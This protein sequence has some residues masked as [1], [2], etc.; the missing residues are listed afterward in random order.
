V[1]N[2][3]LMLCDWSHMAPNLLAASLASLVEFI[4]ALTVVLAVGAVRG[5]RGAL[6]GAGLALRVLLLLVIVLGPAITQIPQGVV[7][8]AL[9]ALLLLFGMR[10][11]RK[12]I[13]RAAG[14]IPL[15]YDDAAYAKESA[16][17]RAIGGLAAGWDRVAVSTSFKITMVEGIEVVFIGIAMGLRGLN[18]QQL[19]ERI[20]RSPNAISSLERGLVAS[21]LRHPRTPRGRPQYARTRVRRHRY[22]GPNRNAKPFWRP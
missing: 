19:A 22:R 18:Q 7:Q 15:H 16:A 9:G 4:E 11:L 21:N 8:L 17:L 14:V 3:E 10:W 1:E 12:A 20:N 6:G 5:W 13:L 2:G